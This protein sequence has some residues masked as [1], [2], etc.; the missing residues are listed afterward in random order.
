MTTLV[1]AAAASETRYLPA[2]VDVVLTG[3]GKTAAAI[4]TTRALAERT[5]QERAGLQVVNLGSCGALRPG[6]RGVFEPGEPSARY[7][8]PFQASFIIFLKW[9][10]PDR[11]LDWGIRRMLK[12]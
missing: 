9:L 5:P 3:L 12:V 11:V 6:M 2:D 8:V 1:V 10:L 4:A 7:P